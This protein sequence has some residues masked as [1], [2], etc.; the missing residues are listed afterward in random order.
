MRFGVLAP[1]VALLLTA[2]PGC[3][4]EP[5][6]AK[7]GT[8]TYL[9]PIQRPDH[10]PLPDCYGAGPCR[11]CKEHVY[12]FGVNGLNPMCLGNFNGMLNYFRDEG[13]HNT[14]FGQL[15]TSHVFCAKIREIRRCDPHAR[16]VLIGFSWG[17]N[18]VR[19]MAHH[20]ADE[21]CRIDLLIYLV[22]DLVGNCDESRPANVD[23]IV[24]VRGKGLVLLGGDL[25]FN[26][27]DIDGAINHNLGC[28]H[29]LAP[30]R[31]EALSLVMH[32][33]MIQACFP[34]ATK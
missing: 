9:H 27:A 23:R 17:A 22:G 29:I 14:Y 20:L 6:F 21:G 18:Y 1:F 30:S 15:Y 24:N 28:R 11:C 32:E 31:R 3:A 13:F 16:I 4:F 12:I 10:I 33:L 5:F 26:G 25:F 34:E 2:G 19:K 7:F 8:G